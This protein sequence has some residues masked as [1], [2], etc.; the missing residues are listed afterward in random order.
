LQCRAFPSHRNSSHLPA[1]ALLNW[2]NPRPENKAFDRA[3]SLAIGA[4]LF[5]WPINQASGITIR[6]DTMTEAQASNIRQVL[7][8][9]RNL[10]KTER[11]RQFARLRCGLMLMPAFAAID[12]MP[13]GE[14]ARGFPKMSDIDA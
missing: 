9:A 3:R 5:I 12:L 10:T 14:E 4:A 2:P 7:G 8:W 1:A 13:T 6:E 11:Q